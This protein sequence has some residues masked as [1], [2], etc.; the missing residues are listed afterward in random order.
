MSPMEVDSHLD[1]QQGNKESRSMDRTARDSPGFLTLGHAVSRSGRHPFGFLILGSWVR[2]PP[3][4]P[5]YFNGLLG[6]TGAKSGEISRL[7]S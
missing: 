6:H 5:N 3:G 1:S 2:I 7:D 4:A